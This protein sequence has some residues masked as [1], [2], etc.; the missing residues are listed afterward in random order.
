MLFFDEQF[1]GLRVEL[2]YSVLELKF[3][4][5]KFKRFKSTISS[6]VQGILCQCFMCYETTFLYA[7]VQE[8]NWNSQY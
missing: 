5:L 8:L 7:V 3:E 4:F 1:I 6:K 2:K